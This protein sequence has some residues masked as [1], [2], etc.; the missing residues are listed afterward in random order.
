[1]SKNN[2]FLSPNEI[3]S[4][5]GNLQRQ[6]RELE[7]VNELLRHS[8]SVAETLRLVRYVASLNA[9][10]LFEKPAAVH[11]ALTRMLESI[12]DDAPASLRC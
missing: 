10:K 9:G 3:E 2:E 6:K 11:A 8:G 4:R 1:M 7:Y 5:I 12:T